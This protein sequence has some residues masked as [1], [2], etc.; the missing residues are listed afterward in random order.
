MRGL[1]WILVGAGLAGLGGQRLAGVLLGVVG[2]V[3]A[4]A[5]AEGG[6]VEL[7]LGEVVGRGAEVEE[8]HD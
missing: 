8:G 2:L 4:A 5:G 6:R 1:F 3:G 7:E